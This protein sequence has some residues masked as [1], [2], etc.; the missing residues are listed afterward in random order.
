[1]APSDLF[2][3]KMHAL[4]CRPYK[5]RVKARDWYDFIWYVKKGI[6]LHLSHLE[7]RMRQSGHYINNQPLTSD[8][9]IAILKEKITQVNLQAAKEDIWR[10]IKN[11]HELDVWS[12]DFFM[13][14][15]SQIQ[16]I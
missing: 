7:T 8:V 4:L 2:A 6:P 3:G 10:F 15:C 5:V 13:A 14:L 11:P 16:I 12:N 1:M 9:F